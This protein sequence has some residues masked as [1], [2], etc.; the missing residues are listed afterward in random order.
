MRFIKYIEKIVYQK[1]LCMTV[2]NYKLQNFYAFRIIKTAVF[3]FISSYGSR[4]TAVV[5]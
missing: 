1:L 2:V 4:A 3:K 5:S